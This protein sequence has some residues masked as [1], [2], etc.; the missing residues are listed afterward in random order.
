MGDAQA[1]ASAVM[2]LARRKR[3]RDYVPR[4][5]INLMELP[6]EMLA[7]ILDWLV[8]IDPVTLLGSVPEV[9]SRLRGNVASLVRGEFG[10]WTPDRYELSHRAKDP[11]WFIGEVVGGRFPRAKALED[12]RG[13][14]VAS[15]GAL[16]AAVRLFPRVTGR[17]QLS[18]YQVH[19]LARLGFATAVADLL[20]EK[21]GD[22]NELVKREYEGF[23][24]EQEYLR[25]DRPIFTTPLVEAIIG[26]N[27]RT[28]KSL[29]DGGADIEARHRHNAPLIR[30]CEVVCKNPDFGLGVVTELLDRGANLN[31]GNFS[32]SP[33]LLSIG[34]TKDSGNTDLMKLL[35]DYGAEIGIWELLA[36][37][38]RPKDEQ[39][40]ILRF[41]L[42][43]GS[44][45]ERETRTVTLLERV[46]ESHR[47]HYRGNAEDMLLGGVGDDICTPGVKGRALRYFCGR[48]NDRPIRILL[49]HGADVN[50]ADEYGRTPLICAA[51]RNQRS[52]CELLIRRGANKEA[53]TVPMTAYDFLASRALRGLGPGLD[54][55]KPAAGGGAM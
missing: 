46:L 12:I 44:R 1:P 50:A 18:K 5:E 47:N 3:D 2:T 9:N 41:L 43:Q 20:K 13:S 37:F 51:Q 34:S 17:D 28:V 39:R 27:L 38:N 15:R 35:V 7:A 25:D 8:K 45:E 52:I 53:T 33:L 6:D 23:D 16:S 54:F 48:E 4:M 42:T 26:N 30:A 32:T 19:D 11:D 10:E 40:N 24:T 14:P 29:L 21:A 49:A 22:I 36:V 31:K 55:M